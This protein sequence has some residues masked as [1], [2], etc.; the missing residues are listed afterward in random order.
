MRRPVADDDA[1]AQ[2]ARAAARDGVSIAVA[3]SLTGGS[4]ASRRAQLPDAGE[5]FRGSVVAYAASVKHDLLGVPDVPIV[6]ETSA[7]AMA[8]GASSLLDADVVIAVTGEGGPEPQDDVPVGT[9]WMAIT[10]GGRTVARRRQFDGDPGDVVRATCDD[11]V[12]WL[13]QHVL[14]RAPA[15]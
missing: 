15:R 5:W 8:E 10:D 6:S 7:R 3:E 14:S 4:L 11:A 13:S 9:V 1:G 12:G 2:L